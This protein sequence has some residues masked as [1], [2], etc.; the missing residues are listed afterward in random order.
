MGDTWISC[1][2]ILGG[3]KSV[4]LQWEQKNKGYKKSD[5][6]SEPNPDF[7]QQSLVGVLVL[8]K[9]EEHMAGRNPGQSNIVMPFPS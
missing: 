6:Y 4:L 5:L 9:V 2:V 3:D 8:V 1:Y 7:L